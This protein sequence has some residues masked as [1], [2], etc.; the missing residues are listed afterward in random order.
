MGIVGIRVIKTA[1]AVV[2]AIFLA[3]CAGLHSPNST[4]LLAILGVDVTKRKGLR[5]SLQRIAASLLGLLLAAALFWLFGF[6]LWVIGLYILILFPILARF[7]LKEGAVTGAVVMFH[8]FNEKQLTPG[9]ILNEIGLLLIGLGTAT[10]INIVYM[11]NADREL[12]ELRERLE[13]CFSQIFKEIANH[14]RDNTY[15]WNGSELLE[16]G[17]ILQEA[18]DAARRSE[19]NM[20]FQG[21]AAWA[22]YFSMRKQQMD[23]VDRMVQYVAQ[24]Y[25]TLPHGE[26]MASVFDELSEDVKSDY[27]TGRSEKK[28]ETLEQGFRLMNLPATRE[29]FEVRSALLQLM[30]ELKSY[31]AVAK[32][33]KKQME[34][35]AGAGS[36]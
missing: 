1:V 27:Y 5:T 3:Q 36:Q 35:A 9:L 10:V 24:A 33:E 14:L 17:S 16:A 31:L 13:T 11:P 25:E 19:E 29:E 20:L 30:V 34:P 32:R 28:L 26:L 2:A 8:L 22:V 18:L 21:N 15:I 6:H 4:G 12:Q 23:S 7:Q